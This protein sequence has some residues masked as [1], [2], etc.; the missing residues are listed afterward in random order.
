M[1]GENWGMNII[2]R[3]AGLKGNTHTLFICLLGLI[4]TSNEA[5]VCVFVTWS[6]MADDLKCMHVSIVCRP[7]SS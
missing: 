6:L 1:I 2:Y 7:V 5:L 4:L 3:S